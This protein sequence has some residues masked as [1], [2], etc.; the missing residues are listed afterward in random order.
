MKIITERKKPNTGSH[1]KDDGEK[2]RECVFVCVCEKD[3]K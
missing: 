2:E 3:K 1:L